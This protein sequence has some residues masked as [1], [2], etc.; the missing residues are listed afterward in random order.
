MEKRIR[1]YQRIFTPINCVSSTTRSTVHVARKSLGRPI[2]PFDGSDF[3][4]RI[5]QKAASRDYLLSFSNSPRLLSAFSRREAPSMSPENP[6]AVRSTPST[7]QIPCTGFHQKRLLLIIFTFPRVSSAS[8][9]LLQLLVRI[10]ASRPNP[11]FRKLL[12]HSSLS[13]SR[14]RS[15][16]PATRTGDGARRPRRGGGHPPPPPPCPF[17][18]RGCWPSPTVAGGP[19][20]RRP[21]PRRGRPGPAGGRRRCFVPPDHDFFCA[22]WNPRGVP[23][24]L[25]LSLSRS[26]PMRFIAVP[27]R[28]ALAARGG[29]TKGSILWSI[30]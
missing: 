6:S 27:G 20:G 14:L 3:L 29:Y 13:L 24:P 17:P 11:S 10:P 15:V 7:A 19:N 8:L 18:S 9:Y 21:R 12:F 2:C 22:P 16:S 28:P 23:L 30:D 25:S 26:L 1:G 5:S 4:H